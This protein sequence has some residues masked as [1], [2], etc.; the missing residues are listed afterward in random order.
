MINLYREAS[1]IAS[2]PQ[3]REHSLKILDDLLTKNGY[4]DPR[5]FINRRRRNSNNRKSDSDD[6][7]V[8]RLDF[9]S[10]SISNRIR[11]YIRQNH[12]PIKVSFS[13]ARKLRNIV[14]NNRPYDKKKCINNSCKICPLLIT[15]NRDC[16]VKNVVYKIRCKICNQIYIGET[17]RRAHD[18]LGEHLRYAKYPLTPSNVNQSF[19]LHY[20]SLHNGL[21]PNLEFDILRIESNTVRRKI[22]E[23]MLIIKLKPSINKREELDTIKRFLISNS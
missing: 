10:D 1:R 2:G 6:R 4:Q 8:L 23:A 3:E 12:L 14:C 21:E 11:N 19:A 20:N 13:P 5:N 7:T 9:I 22:T 18:R 16:E 17:C 15:E